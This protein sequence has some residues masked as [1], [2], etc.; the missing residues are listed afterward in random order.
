MGDSL[1]RGL[2]DL[3]ESVE[4]PEEDMRGLMVD[5]LQD[6]VRFLRVECGRFLGIGRTHV[7]VPVDATAAITPEAVTIDRAGEH[8]HTAPRYDPALINAYD[9]RYWG[10]LCGYYG[11]APHRGMGYAYPRYPCYAR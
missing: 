9:G 4:R 1:L 2:H 5:D 11:Y 6:K 3:G 8:L 7:M 10:G